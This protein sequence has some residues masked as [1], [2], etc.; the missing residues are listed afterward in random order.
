MGILIRMSGQI[1]VEGALPFAKVQTRG[2]VGRPILGAP[3]LVGIG[4]EHASPPL[5]KNLRD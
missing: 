1:F 2:Q 4:C 5:G 3:V